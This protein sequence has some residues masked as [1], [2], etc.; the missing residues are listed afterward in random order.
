MSKGLL[1]SLAE[2]GVPPVPEELDERVH[3]RLNR[4]L[5]AAHLVDLALG[6]LPWAAVQLFRGVCHLM[7]ATLTGRFEGDRGDRSHE[8]P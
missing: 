7:E 8:V 2:H 6:A 1:D 4:A 5:L 3:Q